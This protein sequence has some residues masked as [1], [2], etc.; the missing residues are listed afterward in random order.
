MGQLMIDE[1]DR[2]TKGEPMR[3]A[4]SKEKAAILA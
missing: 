2:W 3:W 1:F 4:I